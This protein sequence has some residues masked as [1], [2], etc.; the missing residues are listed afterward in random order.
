ML[1]IRWGASK[2][3][4]FY[5]M[6]IGKSQPAI[7]D[8]DNADANTGGQNFMVTIG[9]FFRTAFIL[10]FLSSPAL[11]WV[12]AAPNEAIFFEDTNFKGASLN[13]RLGPGERHVL[14]P[15]LGGLEKK[16]SSLILG[17]NVKVLAF[18]EP[19]FQGGVVGYRNTIAEAMP[20]DDQICS[21]IV[22]PKGVPPY[23]VLFIHK[24]LSEV[25]APASRV[26]HYITGD[27]SFFPLPESER[28]LE[29]RFSKMPAKWDDR[30]RY[31]Y[32]SP[33]VQTELFEDPGLKGRS[34]SLPPPDPGQEVV[35]DLRAF[36][37]YDPK[38]SPPGVISSLIVRARKPAGGIRHQ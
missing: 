37:F 4:V 17:D 10:L 32:V 34:L 7:W 11:A 2:R 8:I 25:K 24:R 3:D 16:I 36:G 14:L 33:S 22:G 28:E 21:L 27:G 9:T 20:D 19:D 38:K 26:W 23:G 12:H 15:R 6:K 5:R 30:V 31:V 13:L 29:V 18:T 1:L 35:F